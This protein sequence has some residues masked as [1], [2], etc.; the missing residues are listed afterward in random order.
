MYIL[1]RLLL[2]S[3]F[4]TS[5]RVFDLLKWQQKIDYLEQDAGGAG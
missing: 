5:A 4:Y 3:V 2:A 1:I